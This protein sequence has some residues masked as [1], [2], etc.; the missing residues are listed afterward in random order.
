MSA[1]MVLV[2]DVP[3]SMWLTAN[4]RYHWADRAQRVRDLRLLGRL[5]ARRAGLPKGLA[6]VRVEV[7]V[8]G[9]TRRRVDP[10][11][12]YPT[13]KAVVDG[14]VDYGVV[15]DDDHEHLTGPDM[16]AGMPAPGLPTGAH[17]LTIHI[18]PTTQAEEKQ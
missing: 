7:L 18:T 3:A 16:R 9:R 13:I 5:R 12:A 10:A 2:V 14:L 1:P 6:F 17:R 4:G 11:N 15:D 8:H